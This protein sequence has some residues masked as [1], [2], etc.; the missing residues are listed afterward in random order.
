MKGRSPPRSSVLWWELT[1]S[2]LSKGVSWLSEEAEEEEGHS[3]HKQLGYPLSF[4]IKTPLPGEE[5]GERRKNGSISDLVM[6]SPT[7]RTVEA[8]IVH[9]FPSRSGDSIPP[10][11]PVV[12]VQPPPFVKGRSW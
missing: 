12:V 10:P 11:P 1:K 4:E 3:A 6:S 9:D 7:R 2:R 8:R 5:D